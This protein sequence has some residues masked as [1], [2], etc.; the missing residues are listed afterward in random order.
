MERVT[1]NNYNSAG[2][3]FHL[4]HVNA[5]IF[6]Y[7]NKTIRRVKNIISEKSV[8]VFIELCG[9]LRQLRELL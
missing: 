9:I 8:R 2:H 3:L 7:Y 1:E 5:I 4:T 6:F